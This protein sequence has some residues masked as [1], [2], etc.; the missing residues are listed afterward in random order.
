MLYIHIVSLLFTLLLFYFFAEAIF[1]LR[2]HFGLIGFSFLADEDVN[3]CSL[4]G[5][6][7]LLLSASKKEENARD[8]DLI[9]DRKIASCIEFSF[10]KVWSNVEVWES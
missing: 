2:R 8:E 7:I 9:L 6:T 4:F 3:D 10:A 1:L 5:V